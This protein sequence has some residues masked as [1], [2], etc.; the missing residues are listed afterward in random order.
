[1]A[2]KGKAN[3][4]APGGNNSP[5]RGAPG[6][7]PGGA[8]ASARPEGKSSPCCQLAGM[9][10][11]IL[12]AVLPMTPCIGSGACS[13]MACLAGVIFLWHSASYLFC[14]HRHLQARSACNA[15]VTPSVSSCT[16]MHTQQPPPACK[17]SFIPHSACSPAGSFQ[18]QREFSALQGCSKAQHCPHFRLLLP[19]PPA[20]ASQFSH[21]AG[22]LARLMRHRTHSLLHARAS[23]HTPSA[24][25]QEG[26]RR[27]ETARRRLQRARDALARALWTGLA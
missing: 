5:G 16:A 24:C 21:N 7:P 27:A 10:E 4:W 23:G 9:H 14:Y 6:A 20:G 13:M 3:G 1:M 19:M 17:R 22:T 15:C 12:C 25:L 8:K 18:V 26:T 11:L 2:G